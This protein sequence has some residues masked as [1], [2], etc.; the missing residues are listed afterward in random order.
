[1]ESWYAKAR[2][3][4]LREN[5]RAKR[6]F[7]SCRIQLPLEKIGMEGG[8][9]CGDCHGLIMEPYSVNTWYSHENMKPTSFPL[10]GTEFILCPGCENLCL[11]AHDVGLC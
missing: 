9:L 7:Q 10:H 5:I 8:S 4:D 11:C 2:L 6:K 1:M 3:K